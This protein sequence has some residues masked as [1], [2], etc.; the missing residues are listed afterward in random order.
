MLVPKNLDVFSCNP[1]NQENNL[2]HLFGCFQYKMSYVVN[3]HHSAILNFSLD[4]HFKA[5][6]TR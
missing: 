1:T 5:N 6:L 3:H 2:K 4:L